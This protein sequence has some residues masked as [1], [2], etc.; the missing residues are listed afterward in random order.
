MD[1]K[2]KKYLACENKRRD[3]PNPSRAAGIVGVVHR[4]RVGTPEKPWHPCSVS[5]A[6]EPWMMRRGVTRCMHLLEI[7][8]ESA[9]W[10]AESCASGTS[11]PTIN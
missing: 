6:V 7:T 2:R 8:I 3:I 1:T 4:T 11:I 5:R 9:Q 10:S